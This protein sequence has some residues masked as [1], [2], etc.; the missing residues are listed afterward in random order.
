MTTAQSLTLRDGRTYGL[1]AL[2][3]AGNTLLPLVFHLVPNGGQMFLPIFFFT[4]LG[5]WRYGLTVGLM[6][7]LFSPLFSHLVMGMPSTAMLAPVA[8]QSII[9]AVLAALVARRVEKTTIAAVATVAVASMVLGLAV[10]RLMVD[11]GTPMATA[12]VTA[13]PGM[14]LQTL[15]VW[16]I[17]KRF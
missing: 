8:A 3:V 1:S 13:V 5:A 12:F 6:A 4:L 16:W 14:A 2:F 10:E 9:T 17:Q 11:T 7:G 15:G